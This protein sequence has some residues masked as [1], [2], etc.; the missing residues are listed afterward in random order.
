M[1]TLGGALNIQ[2]FV[3]GG[4]VEKVIASYVANYYPSPAPSPV[5]RQ[6]YLEGTVEFENWSLLSICQ[7]LMAG[8]MNLG[9]MPTKSI[10]GSSMEENEDFGFVE[11]QF[12]GERLGIVREIKPDLSI[13]HGW[14]AD[15]EGNTIIFNPSAEGVML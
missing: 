11:S 1:I 13:Y 5:I 14:C 8:A 10:T 12:K 15:K 6:S 7:R 3:F 9:F 2:L 4:L